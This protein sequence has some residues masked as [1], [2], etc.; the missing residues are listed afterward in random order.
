[1]RAWWTLVRREL[2]SYFVSWVGYVII[3]VVLLLF[4]IAFDLL[5]EELNGGETDRPL[6]EMFYPVFL[7]LT[8]ILA[9]PLIT[10]RTFAHEKFTGTFE[11]LMTTPVS[12]LQV[13]LAKFGGAMIFYLI[14][15]SPLVACVFV[16]RHFSNDPVAIDPRTLSSTFVGITLLGALYM[17]IGCF[18]SSLTR[19]QIISAMFAIAIGV[20]LGLLSLLSEAFSG[21]TGWVTKV[22]AHLSL[23]EHMRDFS[24]GVIDTRPV[25]LYLSLTALFLFLTL[26]SVESRRWKS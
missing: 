19:S 23:T 22:F 17:A 5:L 18:A 1:M 6:T 3:A 8:L 16:V 26:K 9:A 13:V 12:D 11:T 21:H 24:R 25:I 20:S 14:M 15:W 7:W 10:M 4:G 2:G